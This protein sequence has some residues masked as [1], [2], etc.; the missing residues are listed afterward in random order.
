MTTPPP[1]PFD[2]ATDPDRHTIWDRLI[3]AD[4]EAF[5]VGD[6]Q[7]IDADFDP[8][9]FEGLRAMDSCDPALW[10]IVF[11]TLQSYRDNWLKSADEFRRKKFVGLTH[12][13]ALYARCRLDRIDINGERAIAVKKFSGTV[14]CEDGSSISGR[15]QTLYRL[16]RIAGHWKVVGFVGFLPLPE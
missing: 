12:R 1:N 7:R 14:P 6:W 2:P 3:V 15:R 4:T 16:H 11:P 8:T 13:D 5:A 9:R 10:Q